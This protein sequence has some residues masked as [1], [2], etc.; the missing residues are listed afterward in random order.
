MLTKGANQRVRLA[1]DVEPE[2]R[3]KIKVAA[4]ERDLSVRD[5]VVAILR[6]A[7]IAEEQTDSRDEGREWSTLSASSFARDWDSPEDQA[8][9]GLA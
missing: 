7:L 6:R 5:F 1:I 4:A 3:R 2:L 8:Y 9:D